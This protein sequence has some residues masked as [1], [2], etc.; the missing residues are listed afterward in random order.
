MDEII[1][2][3][4]V[5]DEPKAIS[6]LKKMLSKIPC[7][8]IIGT[9]TNPEL[10]IDEILKLK[11]DLL[12]LD[13]EMPNVSGLSLV[14][15]LLKKAFRAF[16]IF[17]TAYNKYALQAL[18]LYAVDYLLKPIGESEL[19]ESIERFSNSEKKIEQAKKIDFLIT[20]FS[21]NRNLQVKNASSIYDSSEIAYCLSNGSDTKVYLFD[22]KEEIVPLNIG[23]FLSKFNT[24]K[25]IRLGR[26]LAINH[27]FIAFIDKE[28]KVCELQL[29]YGTQKI[30]I[31]EIQL[32]HL[33]ENIPANPDQ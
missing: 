17:T 33:C 21:K 29:L 10:A 26:S 23:A 25:I 32:Q 30:P 16:V 18:K 22:G 3:F 1:R 4:I 20:F 24:H 27:D 8:E 15:D 7:I 5:D 12:F 13:I 19:K 28:Q 6:I 9:N 31:T 2:V 14:E 11:P